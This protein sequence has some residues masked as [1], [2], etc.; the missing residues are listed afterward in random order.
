MGEISV[1]ETDSWTPKTDSGTM[2][3]PQQ[4][5]S[6]PQAESLGVADNLNPKDSAE[7]TS[8][9]SYTTPVRPL[10]SALPRRPYRCLPRKRYRSDSS[11]EGEI[12]ESSPL[13]LPFP[14]MFGGQGPRAAVDDSGEENLILDSERAEDVSVGEEPLLDEAFLMTPEGQCSS[15]SIT[16]VLG[17]KSCF[18]DNQSPGASEEEGAVAFRR[19]LGIER[20]GPVSPRS[21]RRLMKSLVR[22]CCYGILKYCLRERLFET[23]RGCLLN[24]PGQG[25][26]ECLDRTDEDINQTIRQLCIDLCMESILNAVMA[27]GYSMDCLCLTEK[28]LA[29]GVA[30]INHIYL[31]GDP[32]AALHDVIHEEDKPLVPYIEHLIGTRNL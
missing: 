8:M 22:V 3:D 28:H 21:R 25:S 2:A 23:C 19:Q 1:V 20:T 18:C 9:F 5:A 6:E 15:S 14:E 10:V 27:L 12:K 24:A 30:I 31:A 16:L 29:Q 11:E 13:I 26:H 17:K 32:H 4:T 7:G